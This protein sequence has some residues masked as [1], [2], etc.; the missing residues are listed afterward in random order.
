MVTDVDRYGKRRDFS[1]YETEPNAVSAGKKGSK[2][3]SSGRYGKK[4]RMMRKQMELDLKAP[5]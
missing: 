4:D 5:R 1:S 2:T 3:I